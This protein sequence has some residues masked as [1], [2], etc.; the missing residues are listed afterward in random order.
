VGV[1]TV[2][3]SARDEGQGGED[4]GTGGNGCVERGTHGRTPAC[5]CCTKAFAALRYVTSICLASTGA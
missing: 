1:K 3:G 5:L 2:T 4:I